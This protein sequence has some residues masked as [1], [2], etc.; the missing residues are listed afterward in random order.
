MARKID[1]YETHFWTKVRKTDSCW[2]WTAARGWNNGV[3]NSGYGQY[4]VH[5]KGVYAHRY[6]WEITNGPIPEK[7]L[8]LHKCD[9][10]ICVRPD[11]LF[12]GTHNDNMADMTMK[13]RRSRVGSPGLS[14]PRAKLTKEQ[15]DAIRLKHL[16]FQK[17]QHELAREYGVC[18]TTIS[19][20]TRGEHWTAA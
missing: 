9:N 7:T 6:A 19:R 4:N 1:D 15:A 13:G 8:V 11:H 5:R 17:T 18:Q 3:P 16:Y 10:P 12:L 14:N 2:E 20:V